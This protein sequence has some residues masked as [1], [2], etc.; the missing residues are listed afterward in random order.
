M[1]ATVFRVARVQGPEENAAIVSRVVRIVVVALALCAASSLALAV[2]GGHW[3]SMRDVSIGPQASSQCFGGDCQAASLEWVGGSGAWIR[4]GV[5]TWGAGLV[6]VLC[7]IGM[8]AAVASRRAGRLP[9]K[10]VIAAA[11]A[12]TA[13]GAA[14]VS[15]FP[16]VP[17]MGI[18]RGVFFYFGGVVLAV[19]AA[20]G[21]LRVRSRPI[22]G[23]AGAT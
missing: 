5:A 20:V 15:Q 22:A 18:D 23:A 17:G 19:A 1:W 7:L 14:F 11:V 6:G 8:A 21:T 4:F 10:M 9:A 12:A 3:W 13:V 16:G 2:E